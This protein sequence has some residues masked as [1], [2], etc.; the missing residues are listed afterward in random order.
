[1]NKS[2]SENQSIS[3]HTPP[4]GYAALTPLYDSAIALLTREHIWRERFARAIAPNKSDKIWDVGSGTGSL[5]VSLLTLSPRTTYLGIDPDL[6]AIQRSRKKMEKSQLHATFL[7]TY[8]TKNIAAQ[9]GS[10]TKIVSSLVFHQVPLDEKKRILK[11]MFHSLPHG[12][13]V[14]IADYGLQRSWL[15]KLLFRLTVQMLDGVQDTQPNADGIIPELICQSGFVDVKET[16]HIRTAT[17]TISLYAGLKP[18]ERIKKR[19]HQQ[20]MSANHEI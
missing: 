10:P 4:L 12:G 2:H 9:E 8:L 20:E 17:G 6:R 11:L 14:H 7:H 16:D 13:A 18:P 1:M 5:A 15:M 3:S 19:Q